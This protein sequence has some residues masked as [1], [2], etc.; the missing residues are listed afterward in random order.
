MMRHRV[1]IALASAVCLAVFP[2]ITAYAKKKNA[3]EARQFLQQIPRDQRIEQ[4]LNRLTFGARPDDA[5]QAKA[6][7]LKVWIDNQLHPDRIA[8]NQQACVS[9]SFMLSG[10]TVPIIGFRTASAHRFKAL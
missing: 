9:D 6:I 4:A 8:E 3:D 1:L 2:G 5:A 7:G 10:R